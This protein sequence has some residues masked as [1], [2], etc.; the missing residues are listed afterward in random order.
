[1]TKAPQ[2]A[3]GFVKICAFYS[4]EVDCRLDMRSAIL[5]LRR[6]L[7]ARRPYVVSSCLCILTAAPEKASSMSVD[8]LVTIS[9]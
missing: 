1:M 5:C 3:G 7:S 9:D 8:L 2:A 4:A 6:R